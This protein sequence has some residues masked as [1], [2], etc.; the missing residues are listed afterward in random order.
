MTNPTQKK[1]LVTKQPLWNIVF[2]EQ[3]F[4]VDHTGHPIAELS[5]FGVTKSNQMYCFPG[6][7]MVGI[8]F[9][10]GG[11]DAKAYC[12]G[13]LLKPDHIHA[14]TIQTGYFARL[15]PGQFSRLFGISTSEISPY[16]IPLEDIVPVKSYI[17]QIAQA[18]S[19]DEFQT[20]FCRM[21]SEIHAARSHDDLHEQVMDYMVRSILRDGGESSV[22]SLIE[23][24]GY[25]RRQISNLFHHHV[26]TTIKQLCSH[27]RFQ[28]AMQACLAGTEN[29]SFIASEFGYYDQSHFNREFRSFSSMS[30]RELQSLVFYENCT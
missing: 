1:V 5:T 3:R 7:G 6:I 2:D 30:P 8:Q 29:L 10:S 21:T 24:T 14:E 18:K 17:E 9:A 28:R 22:D 13:V 19:L 16:G 25:S 12:Y 4:L 26:G 27:V 20:L 11:G 23:Q 15:Y